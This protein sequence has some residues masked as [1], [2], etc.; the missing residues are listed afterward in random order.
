M[1]HSDGQTS[2]LELLKELGLIRS[3]LAAH[4]ERFD[5][6]GESHENGYD[7]QPKAKSKLFG[8]SWLF[9][10]YFSAIIPAKISASSSI[11]P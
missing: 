6:T 11:L 4:K 3:V 2:S 1:F 8:T 5:L 10:G 9:L 7:N